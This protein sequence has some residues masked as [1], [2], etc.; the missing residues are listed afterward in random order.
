MKNILYLAVITL[1]M[2]CTMQAQEKAVWHT[3]VKKAIDIATKNDR[4][5]L[6][7]FTGSDW[8][9]WCKR[10]QR[11][12]FEKEA[13]EKWANKEVVLVELDFPRR[14]KLADDLRQQ[15][16]QLQQVFRVQGYPTVHL[17]KAV[18]NGKDQVSFSSFG[19]T[20]YVAG[21]PSKWIANAEALLNPP[22][23]EKW[24]TNV[25]EA[26][27]VSQKTNKPLLMFFTGSDWCG[28]CKRLQAEV[29]KTAAFNE[30]AKD[31][32]VLVEVD[33]PRRTPQDK[34]IKEQNANLQQIFKVKGYPS[35]YLVNPEVKGGQISLN[36]YGHTGYVAGG[37]KPF[38]AKLKGFKAAK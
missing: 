17:V 36:A 24:Y 26:V 16:A 12:V 1:M 35:L 7:F 38:I 5:L 25:N 22:A 4:P 29:L 13:F 27:S 11:E 32:V 34:A 20:G 31:N 15:N 23:Q 9:G 37:P 14:T 8:C 2:S 10:L 3:D 21:G 30:W 33:Y 19:K 28:W 18:I 6:L